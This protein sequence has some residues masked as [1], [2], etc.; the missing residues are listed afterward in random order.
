LTLLRVIHFMVGLF[1][2]DWLLIQS[3][4]DG[5]PLIA[6]CQS[7]LGGRMTIPECRKDAHCSN[8]A[9]ALG[10]W[11]ELREATASPWPSLRFVFLPPKVFPACD[12]FGLGGLP[13]LWSTTTSENAS[14]L[15][16]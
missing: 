7:D 3:F 5:L 16:V 10:L 11:R 6:L 4:G 14:P 13:V 2:R 9:L 1:L 8:P 15:A 12:G